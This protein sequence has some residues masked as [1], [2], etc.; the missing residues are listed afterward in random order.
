MADIMLGRQ[1]RHGTRGRHE[2]KKKSF[3]GVPWNRQAADK[4]EKRKSSYCAIM[5]T[6]NDGDDNFFFFLIYIS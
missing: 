2:I 4:N 3:A 1:S 5:K 6:D